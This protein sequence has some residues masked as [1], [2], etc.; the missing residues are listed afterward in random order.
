MSRALLVS[1]EDRAPGPVRDWGSTHGA[2]IRDRAVDRALAAN[3]AVPTGR[4][5]LARTLVAHDAESSGA[6]PCEA[7]FDDPVERGALLLL[8]RAQRL[9]I[10]LAD[11][12]L[13]ATLPR[14]CAFQVK[15]A[16]ARGVSVPPRAR[17]HGLSCRSA[18]LRSAGSRL[19]RAHALN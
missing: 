3:A 14:E 6:A 15:R 16:R 7:L 13:I 4:S 2:D 12:C 18:L 10:E 8:E 19:S 17:R 1:K 5:P 11:H 9:I